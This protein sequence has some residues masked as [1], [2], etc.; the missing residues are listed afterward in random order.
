MHGTVAAHHDKHDGDRGWVGGVA[1]ARLQHVRCGEAGEVPGRQ[2]RR[3][4]LYEQ[5]GFGEGI[6][7]AVHA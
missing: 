6:T 2:W 3:E 5:H 4:D 7:D 1:V